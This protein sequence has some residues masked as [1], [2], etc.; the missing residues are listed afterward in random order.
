MPPDQAEVERGVGHAVGDGRT[1][2]QHPVLHA[3]VRAAV[4]HVVYGAVPTVDGAVVQPQLAK[5]GHAAGLEDL[6]RVLLLGDRQQ[7][8]K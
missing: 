3:Q 6:D 2:G 1:C 5:L 4:D 7:G 8:G